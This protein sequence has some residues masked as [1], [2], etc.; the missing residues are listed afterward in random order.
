MEWHYSDFTLWWRVNAEKRGIQCHPITFHWGT[1]CAIGR[2]LRQQSSQSDLIYY[3]HLTHT[4]NPCLLKMQIQFPRH[5]KRANTYADLC[6]PLRAVSAPANR[7]VLCNRVNSCSDVE[8]QWPGTHTLPMCCSDSLVVSPSS[9]WN[10]MSIFLPSVWTVLPFDL[11]LPQIRSRRW[12]FTSAS[13]GPF[14]WQSQECLSDFTVTL[15][16]GRFCQSS[17]LLNLNLLL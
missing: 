10:L 15:G 8:A 12:I 6:Q 9:T 13:Q 16:S 17:H 14:N 2:L 4:G 11:K 1:C 5:G 7:L 3:T